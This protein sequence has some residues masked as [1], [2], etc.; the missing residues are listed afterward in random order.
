MKGLRQLG[1]II[2]V[3]TI[4]LDH[5][6]GKYRT[7]KQEGNT[8]NTKYAVFLPLHTQSCHIAPPVVS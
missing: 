2:P 6:R 4:F 3:D 5:K 1:G 7:Q 8:H